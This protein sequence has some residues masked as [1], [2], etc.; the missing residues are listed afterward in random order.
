PKVLGSMTYFHFD[1]ELGQVVSVERG[2]LGILNP[3]VSTF[4]VPILNQNSTLT[5]VMVAQPITKL[6]GVNALTRI[7]KADEAA[8]RAKLD[9]GTLEVLSGVAQCYHGLLGARR[10]E[11]AL[12]LQ[13]KLLEELGAAK[14]NPDLRI[15][16]LEVRQ[17]LSQVRVQV[18]DLTDQ[19]NDL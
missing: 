10:I 16:L 1:K 7:A 15:A 4:G 13:A 14:P 3:G 11:T 2:K 18:R 5:N 6:I 19:F 12:E 17:G 9:K 8:A